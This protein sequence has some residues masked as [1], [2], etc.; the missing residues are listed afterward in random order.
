MPEY[1]ADYYVTLGKNGSE[2]YSEGDKRT[3]LGVYVAGSKLNQKL[4]DFYGNAAY[5]LSYPNEFDRHQGK[6]GHGIWLHGTPS[7]TY[8]RPP[9]AS[10]GCVVISNPDLKSLTPILDNGKTPVVIA[11]NIKWLDQGQ[12]STTKEE[13]TKALELWRQDW[14][15]QDTD[16][17]LAH[18]SSQFFNQTSNFDTWAKE[19]RR[20]QTNKSKVDIKLSNISMFRYPN[21][22]S[23]M[24]VVTFDQD[25]KSANLDSKIRKRQYWNI[26]NNQ[27]KII[28]EGPV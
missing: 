22:Q 10:D 7:S 8:S 12:S 23:E 1:I 20:I 24:A 2:K 14:E 3:P 18:Y 21:M 16:K 5:P 26:E 27:W 4:P 15:A 25:F 19:K 13:F 6:N 28:Y 11:K 9:R 17:Y